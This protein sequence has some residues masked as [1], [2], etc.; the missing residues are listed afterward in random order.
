ME[1]NPDKVPEESRYLL[2]VDVDS[3]LKS[4]FDKQSYWVLAVKAAKRA[5]RRVVTSAYG[6]GTSLTAE[7][8]KTEIE[9]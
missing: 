4:S 7:D 2:E 6:I 9:D 1:C 3:L 5:G 8:K